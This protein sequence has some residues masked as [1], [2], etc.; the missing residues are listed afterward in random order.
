M[1]ERYYLAEKS[2]MGGVDERILLK[3]DEEGIGFVKGETRD[4]FGLD[5]KREPVHLN[6]DGLSLPYSIIPL[7]A[8]QVREWLP[9]NEIYFSR[10]PR[11]IHSARRLN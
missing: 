2:C 6:W 4:R 5:D 8:E 10:F 9:L 1:A 7:V 3:V 11:R